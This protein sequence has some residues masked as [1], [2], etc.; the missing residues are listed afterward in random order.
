MTDTLRGL[1][2]GGLQGLDDQNSPAKW[3]AQSWQTWHHH[4]M[5]VAN[6]VRYHNH[7]EDTIL[8][9]DFWPSHRRILQPKLQDVCLLGGP[10]ARC[11]SVLCKSGGLAQVL[12][13][14]AMVFIERD[15][16]IS[17]WLK[18]T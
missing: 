16:D 7:E 12:P 4:A 1:S 5:Y 18:H 2:G 15:E 17:T 14:E 6:C 11:I 10:D 13:L 3:V 8:S 9:Q